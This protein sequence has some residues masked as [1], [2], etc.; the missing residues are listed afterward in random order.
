MVTPM[1]TPASSPNGIVVV[2]SRPSDFAQEE[3]WSAWYRGTHLPA[4]ADACRAKA[5][6]RWEN[7]ERPHM[8]VSPVGFTHVAIYEFDDIG[9]GAPA[10]LDL[11]DPSSASFVPRH[12]A[13]T[14]IGVEVLRPAGSRWNQR[15]EPGADITGQ[16]IAFVGPND[17]AREDEWNTWLD[18]VHVPD[19]VNSG[20][21]VNA[22]R[23]VRTERARFGLDYLTIYD[24]A[25][26]DLG[27]AVARSGAAMGPARERGR[28]LD[29]HAG[30]LRAVLRA[31]H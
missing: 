20:A 15:L 11:F 19:M 14:I 4:T 24:V 6:A 18:D 25:H 22:T 1:T 16:V 13:H 21:F 29:C 31:D 2:F 23:W 30:G 26:T 9:A 5:T 7:S 12:P 10:L 27:E 28:L 17:P 3:A 8:A